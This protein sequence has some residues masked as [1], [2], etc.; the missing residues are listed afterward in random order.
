MLPDVLG[1]G[2][3]PGVVA[4]K[5]VEIVQTAQELQ[6]V[7]RPPPSVCEAV[8]EP[9]ASNVG[10]AARSVSARPQM[11]V[12]LVQLAQD[13][14]QCAV[15]VVPARVIAAAHALV[16]PVAHE[17]LEVPEGQVK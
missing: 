17:A 16:F 8:A 1:G 10:D 3:D 5:V 6:F 11:G 15:D 14:P 13:G 7:E 12:V 2:R 4:R 9:A